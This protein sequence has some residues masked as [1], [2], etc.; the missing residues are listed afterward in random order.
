[1]QQK[2]VQFLLIIAIITLAL[3]TMFFQT[4]LTDSQKQTT[5]LQN[6]LTDI[7]NSTITNQKQVDDLKTQLNSL[8]NPVYNVTIEN[9]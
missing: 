2:L 3:S 4:K 7:K 5:N 6:Q 9:I 1:M 8:Q